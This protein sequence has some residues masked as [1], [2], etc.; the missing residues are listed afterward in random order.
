[1]DSY[2]NHEDID[3]LIDYNLNEI[4]NPR[5]SAGY[6]WTFYDLNHNT[7]EPCKEYLLI[8]ENYGLISLGQGLYTLEPFALEVINMGGWLKY[9]EEEKLNQQK[10]DQLQEKEQKKLHQEI[11]LNKLKIFTN[12]ITFII[13]TIAI[14][15]ST[16]THFDSNN[17]S[18]ET[19]K[20]NSKIDSLSIRINKI[21]NQL[22]QK[23]IQ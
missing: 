17:N 19:S 16:L 18:D 2:K 8:M 21:E 12:P 23:D 5:L 4:K 20:L 11:I 15:T 1:M 6:Y 7:I 22:K 10:A 14:V 9:L 13:S 3:A